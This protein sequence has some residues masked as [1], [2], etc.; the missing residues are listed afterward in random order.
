MSVHAPRR[1]MPF[2]ATRRPAPGVIHSLGA[3]VR[4][5]IAGAPRWPGASCL[6]STAASCITDATV[7]P[8]ERG[9]LDTILALPLSRL[10]LVAGAGVV[11]ALHT[12]AILTIAGTI[13][14]VV[15]ALAGTHISPGP[16]AAGVPA[17]G[18]WPCLPPVSPR[19]APE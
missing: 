19:S 1:T 12:A 16:A 9:R 17:Y 7:G 3:V 14:L 18:R 5:V 11:T 6:A 13:T 4:R 2:A 15:G 10:I 8:E